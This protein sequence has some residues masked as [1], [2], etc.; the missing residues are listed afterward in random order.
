[1]TSAFNH[2]SLLYLL[3]WAVEINLQ[4]KRRKNQVFV[5]RL[6]PGLWF[7]LFREYGP[8]SFV[9]STKEDTQDFPQC[10]VTTYSTSYSAK[11]GL[12]LN[13]HCGCFN[14]LDGELHPKL[15]L[16]MFCELSENN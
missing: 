5:V 8:M 14:N 1:M 13:F 4:N 10:I 12:Q 6:I 11:L 7:F 3:F 15:K 16:S 2:T 9:T